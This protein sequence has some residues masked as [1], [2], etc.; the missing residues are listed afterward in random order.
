MLHGE[1]SST[2]TGQVMQHSNIPQIANLEVECTSSQS[3]SVQLSAG[4]RAAHTTFQPGPA[5]K[6]SVLVAC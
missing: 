6:L 4:A 3:S 5:D 1:K 2:A